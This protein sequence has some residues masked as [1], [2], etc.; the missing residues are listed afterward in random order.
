MEITEMNSRIQSA[1]QVRPP[2]PLELLRTRFERELLTN[3]E[4]AAVRQRMLWPRVWRDA[5]EITPDALAHLR[6]IVG[7][8]DLAEITG[9]LEVFLVAR[10]AVALAILEALRD[11]GA[12]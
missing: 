10:D 12:Q 1:P 6:E 3:R 11:G 2:S 5:G 9:P 7:H 8:G 4:G